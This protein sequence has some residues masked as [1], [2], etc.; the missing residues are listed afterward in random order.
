MSYSTYLL[1]NQRLI[2]TMLCSAC[3]LTIVV[4]VIE[5]VEEMKKQFTLVTFLNGYKYKLIS[6]L[7]AI[8]I[9][10]LNLKANLMVQFFYR[11]TGYTQ[12]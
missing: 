2:A 9:R 4:G 10:R 6:Q 8:N 12:W 1:G 5:K 7:N 3:F 11:Y